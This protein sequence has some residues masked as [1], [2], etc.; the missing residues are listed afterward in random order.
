MGALNHRQMKWLQRNHHLLERS[1]RGHDA[2]LEGVRRV[3]GRTLEQRPVRD[4]ATSDLRDK[5][6][7]S[8]TAAGRLIKGDVSTDLEGR[9]KVEDPRGYSLSSIP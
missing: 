8:V 4:A 7:G 3:L 5:R 2:S 1:E 9:G 6:A